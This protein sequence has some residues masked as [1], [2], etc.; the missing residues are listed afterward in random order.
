MK[1][2]NKKYKNHNLANEDDRGENLI[3]DFIISSF[4]G[5]LIGFLIFELFIYIIIV[6][7]S[8]R[9]LY[10]FIFELAYG[11]TLGKFQTQTIVM[12]KDGNLPTMIQLIIRSLS[13]FI[14]IFSGISDDERA[15]H[16]Y[17]SNTYVIKDLNLRKIEIRQPLIFIFNQTLLG[18]LIYYIFNHH[19]LETIDIEMIALIVLVIAFISGLFFG[20]KK[21]RSST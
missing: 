12:N 16:D 13:R 1:I 4:L 6:Y 17:S 18:S 2:T 21:M 7:F 10:Y 19:D 20:I 9:F 8:V 3:I 14:S 5:I 11:R 15:I